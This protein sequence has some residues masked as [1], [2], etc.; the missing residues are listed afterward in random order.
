MAGPEFETR[1]Y[2]LQNPDGDNSVAAQLDSSPSEVLEG[3][4]GF[5]VQ[6]VDVAF[7]EKNSGKT[8]SSTLIEVK[9]VMGQMS[10]EGLAPA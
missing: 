4:V 10:L 1:C 2:R 5:F 7:D 6:Q 8:G 9:V 3:H